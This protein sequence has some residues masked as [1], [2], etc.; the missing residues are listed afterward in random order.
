MSLALIFGYLTQGETSILIGVI[1]TFTIVQF[2]ESY[3]LEPFIV[4]DKVDI[5]HFS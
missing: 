3:V 1:L 4:G 2:I 5:L